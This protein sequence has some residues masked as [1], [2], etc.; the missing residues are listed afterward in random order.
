MNTAVLKRRSVDVGKGFKS[1]LRKRQHLSSV[2]DQSL[3]KYIDDGSGDSSI[4]QNK[5]LHLELSK[6]SASYTSTAASVDNGLASSLAM[7]NGSVMP[8]E[9]MSS[10]NVVSSSVPYVPQLTSHTSESNTP[11]T[12]AV[13]SSLTVRPKTTEPSNTTEPSKWRIQ[14]LKFSPVPVTSVESVASGTGKDQQQAVAVAGHQSRMHTGTNDTASCSAQQNTITDGICLFWPNA[15]SL[16]WLDAA[17]ALI[18]N[19]GM[20]TWLSSDLCLGRL[21]KS[22]DSA[23]VNFRRSRKLYRCHYLCGQG[24]AVTLETSV[25]QVAVKTGGGR[26]PLS[27]SVLGRESTIIANVDLDDISSI[28]SPDDPHSTSVEKLSRE[29]RRLEDKAKELLTRARDEVF[30]SL[31]PRMH[32]KRGVCD[33]V[34]IALSELLSLDKTVRSCFTVHYTFSLSCTGCGLPELGM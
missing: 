28:V 1:S 24:K 11:G 4:V 14:H 19:C 3:A 20:S 21:L 23:Q 2:V 18:V 34:L 10:S 5:K 15:D 12:T 31:Q 26:G 27:T 6:S 29:A 7:V 8:T 22:F 25:G 9:N 16:C 32:C 33:T 13:T 17:M 30:E